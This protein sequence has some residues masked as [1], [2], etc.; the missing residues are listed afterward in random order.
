L[1]RVV[2]PGQGGW[3][4]RLPPDAEWDTI[5]LGVGNLDDRRGDGGRPCEWRVRV[6]GS[7]LVQRWRRPSAVRPVAPLIG[8]PDER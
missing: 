5:P 1:H 4:P 6:R 3:H 2:L 7:L 8:T